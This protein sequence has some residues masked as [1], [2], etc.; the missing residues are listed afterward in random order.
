LTKISKFA[1]DIGRGKIWGLV[2]NAGIAMDSNL[3]KMTDEQWDT[4]IAVNVKGVFLST[5][6]II[7]YMEE[8]GC[9]VNISSIVGKVGNFGQTNYASTKAGV[10]GFTK[11]LAKE[12]THKNIRSNAIKL[13]NINTPMIAKMPQKII[14]RMLGLIQMQKLGEPENIADAEVFLLN[15]KASYITGTVLEVTGGWGM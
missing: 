8:G 1:K 3:K 14:D 10:V 9:V 2:N 15:E 5:Q 11:A 4:A 13:G 7:K 12:H 6:N